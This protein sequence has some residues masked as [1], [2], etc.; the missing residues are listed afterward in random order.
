MAP[1]P[2]WKLYLDKVDL[3]KLCGPGQVA[4][5][6]TASSHYAEV[7]GP[8]PSWGGYWSRPVGVS[9]IGAPLSSQ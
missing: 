9:L 1:G 7:V 8:I 3:K 2:L 5:L 6:I 4:Q